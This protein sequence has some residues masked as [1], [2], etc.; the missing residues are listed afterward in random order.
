V[1]VTA[2]CSPPTSCTAAARRVRKLEASATCQPSPDMH[3]LGPGCRAAHSSLRTSC[4]AAAAR[5]CGLT[6]RAATCQTPPRHARVGL[7][8][9][10]WLQELAAGFL[11]SSSQTRVLK[12]ETMCNQ[13]SPRRHARAGGSACLWLQTWLASGLLAQ[14]RCPC[15]FLPFAMSR[16]RRARGD[17][18]QC[19]HHRPPVQR[20]RRS[21]KTMLWS[22]ARHYVPLILYC[23][24]FFISLSSMPAMS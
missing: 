5:G 16:M 20:L 2:T 13:P 6:P 10:R 1:L 12:L 15:R 9:C 4:T 24:Q 8:V 14:Q 19:Q 17:R 23:S 18:S 3:A 21:P 22:S 11:R 7:S